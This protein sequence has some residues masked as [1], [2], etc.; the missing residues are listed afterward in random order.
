MINQ[1][2]S[3]QCETVEGGKYIERPCSQ[4][5]IEPGLSAWDN[6]TRDFFV[7][8]GTGKENLNSGTLL[9]NLPENHSE[10]PGEKLQPNC[11][12]AVSH[13]WLCCVFLLSNCHCDVLT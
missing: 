12:K 1:L 10:M 2:T 8:G 13:V 7:C 11:K 3:R 9:L 6:F 4:T 5:T